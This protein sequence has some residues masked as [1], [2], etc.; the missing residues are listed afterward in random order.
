MLS[1][2]LFLE[3]QHHF[4]RQ[5][6]LEEGL[7]QSEVNDIAEDK[8]GYLWLGTNGGGLCRFNGIDFEVLTKKDGLLEDLVMGLY[9][10]NNFNLWIGSP[11]GIIKY[12]GTDFK[13]YIKSDTALFQ[14]RIQFLETIDGFVW[15]VARGVNGK[16]LILR[17]EGEDVLDY[18]Q[19]HSEIFKDARIFF[20]SQS[21]ARKMLVA[22]SN[23]IFEI[24]HDKIKKSEINKKY[25]LENK[26]LI[27][28]LQD[29]FRN[30][31]VLSF[32]ED[33]NGEELLQLGFD[34]SIKKMNW[35]N[36]IP[37]NSVFRSY[38]DRNG[39]VWIAATSGKVVWFNN[40][41]IK[42][43]NKSNGLKTSLV[44]SFGEDREGNMW[45][46]TSGSGLFK[47]GGDKFVAF[48]EE[49]GL[50]GNIVRCIFEDNK[51][52]VYLGDDNNTISVYDGKKLELLES[53]AKAKMPQSR[54]MIE[55]KNGNIL[56]ATVGG[57]FEYD[58]KRFTPVSN[59]YGLKQQI[60]VIDMIQ[61]ADT[62][63][64]A[65]YGKG[66]MKV[67]PGGKKEWFTSENSDLKSPFITN[68]F[69]DSHNNIWISTTKGVF[70]FDGINFTH[71][72]D[73]NQLNSSWILQSAED[74]VG[75][76]WFATFTGGLNKYD[77]K[78][79]TYYDS[80]SGIKSD[81]I[82]SVIAD[83]EGNIWAG[84]Q[85]GVDKIT[86]DQAG[87][88]VSIQNFDK[89][90]GFVGIE[91]NGGC[92]LLDKDG[93]LWFGTING[94]MMYNPAA[95]RTNHLEPP[96]YLR[97]V[98][99]NFEAPNWSSDSLKAEFDSISPW[100]SL[101]Q[102]LSLPH[103]KNHLAFVF[104]GL[105]YAVPDKIKYKW[106]LNP[107]EQEWSPENDFNMAF[108]P[109]LSPGKYTFKV[110][111]CNNDG[112]WNEDGASYDFEIRPAWY[113]Y[114]YI[115]FLG[116]I[117]IL[118]GILWLVRLRIGKE[119]KMKYELESKIAQNNLEIQKQRVEII[120]QAGDLLRQKEKL[121][122]Q[123]KS[124]LDG[125]NDLERLTKI[126][127]LVTANLST[128]SISEL[129]YQSV[130]KVMST[131]IFSVGIYNFKEKS[132]D[133][134][135]T[136]LMGER[137][138]FTRYL[139]EDNQRLAIYSFTHDSDI[140]INDF[141]NE[142]KDY[143]SELRPVP[144]GAESESVIYIPLK[145]S[146]EVIG[147]IS[148]QSLKKN[149]YVKYHLNFIKN[150]ANYASIALD[151]AL[152]FQSL[153]QEQKELQD[154]HEDVLDEKNLLDMQKEQLLELNIER[155]QLFT[156][157]VKGI[158][159]PLNS[160]IGK[161]KV[162]MSESTNCSDEQ[163]FFFKDM[164]KV[165][166]QQNEVVN[167]VLEV[168]N[169]ENEDYDYQPQEFELLSVLEE[170]VKGQINEAKEKHI[171]VNIS[172]KVLNVNL[173]LSLLVK[174]VENLLSNAIR[175]SPEN[176][177]V[178][179]IAMQSDNAVKVEVHDKGPGL[180]SEEKNKIFE[181]YSK[182]QNMSKENMPTS[183][184]GLYI[185]KK[186]VDVMNGSIRCESVS[187]FGASF[188]VEFPLA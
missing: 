121:E 118:G 123:S 86:L 40:D 91:N 25:G 41:K 165:L 13:Y 6:S 15:A 167:K 126:G 105:C 38:V 80:S 17:F 44:T 161:M 67:S 176:T 120:S 28:L 73:N 135:H 182:L 128:D 104:D 61:D 103:N 74:K 60:P 20:M 162:F 77:G 180:T 163:I 95:E 169:I 147:I 9:S 142:Y 181:K 148:V 68:L 138:P 175:F 166:R 164:L 134:T 131:D 143:I 157:F 151:N 92:N 188:I 96:V 1:F 50:G 153:V 187:G 53:S 141:Y 160:A 54:K 87:D 178:Q 140:F 85:N 14:D 129:L 63:W 84:T 144:T 97:D 82:Y 10:D 55:L 133:F 26:N 12:N 29:K 18:T 36:E 19:Q 90:D 51:G 185:V 64:M 59:A 3:G 108:Y 66:L 136:Y 24:E 32:S 76:I 11:K 102:N 156:L 72:N 35:P 94:A 78:I 110:I 8:F 146:H 127:Q 62:I 39:G 112:I 186:Y 98:L 65:I 4:F 2:P 111:A 170:V 109:S 179:I 75:N 117:F 125:N 21:G 158:Q 45:F 88:I 48:N 16:R 37:L 171:N 52:N 69:K 47:Y 100:F 132:I 5:Y 43:F 93:N 34:G 56:I 30:Q 168:K 42:V 49:S 70:K 159:E 89:N 154:K 130:S 57:L 107:I 33:G 137:Q 115:R 152:K 174:I 27:P 183:G 7:P 155:N 177:N 139:I 83:A 114:V 31:W 22:T 116:A 184:L 173:D 172:S 106:K 23:G 119:K 145:T 101:P 58:K 99:L 46:G 79:F 81:N 150:I 124:L 122:Q 113:Q 149:A 71:F